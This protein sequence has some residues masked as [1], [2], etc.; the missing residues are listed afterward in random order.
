MCLLCQMGQK[1]DH[2]ADS[3]ANSGHSFALTFNQALNDWQNI[4]QTPDNPYNK[5]TDYEAFLTYLGALTRPLT[6]AQAQSPLVVNVS[7]LNNHPDYKEAAIGALQ[8]WST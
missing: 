4:D 7:E 3:A 1:Q 5:D 2:S 8:M 6:P